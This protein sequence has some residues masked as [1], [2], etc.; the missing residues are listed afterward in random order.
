MITFNSPRSAA[1]NGSAIFI[2]EDAED[3][4]ADAKRA[5]DEGKA[6]IAN[7]H[8]IDGHIVVDDRPAIITGNFFETSRYW[9]R[10][11]T[12]ATSLRVLILTAPLAAIWTLLVLARGQKR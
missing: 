2:G 7:A 5:I 8:F 12:L 4:N 10:H 6:V 3:I 1:L 11:R 9:G